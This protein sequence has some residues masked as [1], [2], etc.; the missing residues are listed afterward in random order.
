MWLTYDNEEKV[1]KVLGSVT[2]CA[3]VQK[4]LDGKLL[5]AICQCQENVLIH[6]RIW[7]VVLYSQ[8]I[9]LRISPRSLL[10]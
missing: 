4:H 7:R 1:D 5:P 3:Q 2:V 10:L 8:S 6:A 9:S